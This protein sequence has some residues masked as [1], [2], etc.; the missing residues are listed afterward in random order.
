MP[1]LNLFL[2]LLI[3]LFASEVHA[4]SVHGLID[5]YSDGDSFVIADTAVRLKGIDAPEL[6]QQCTNRLGW[7]YRCGEMAASHLKSLVKGRSVVCEGDERDDYGRLVARCQA[8]ST[9]LNAAMVRDGWAVAFVR[10]DE[11]YLE[12]ES[13]ARS[14]H[15]GIWQGEF[16]QP[17]AFR[18]AS[19][20][21][22][23]KKSNGT[24][25]NC[26]IKGNITSGGD[27]IYHTPW[28]SDHYART[29]ISTRKGER[30]FCSEAEARAAGW[31]PP[32][33]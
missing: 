31:R 6:A 8:G 28:G 7:V 10:Y 27:R 13:D 32:R 21:G 19:W 25:E 2:L 22:A 15:R 1:S 16:Q 3:G 18:A 4:D 23:S 12:A 20:N 14:G 33:R 26:V 30:W 24:G 29:R 17:E 11:S 5:H 9:D